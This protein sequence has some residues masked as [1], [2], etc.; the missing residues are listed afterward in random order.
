LFSRF[1]SSICICPLESYL[2]LGISRHDFKY[3]IPNSHKDNDLNAT[4]PPIAIEYIATTPGVFY[5]C[6][7]NKNSKVSV[8]T[9]SKPIRA[10]SKGINP[11]K[12]R[13]VNLL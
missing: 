13:L 6:K 11:L 10:T 9:D 8:E 2:Y 3:F 5:S 1:S 12:L 4:S 7:A